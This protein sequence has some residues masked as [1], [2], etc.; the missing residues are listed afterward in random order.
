MTERLHER[1]LTLSDITSEEHKDASYNP[2]ATLGVPENA[3]IADVRVAYISKARLYHPDMI[4]PLSSIEARLAAHEKMVQLN[5]AYEMIHTKYSRKEWNTVAGYSFTTVY[6][7]KE[8]HDNQEIKLEGDAEVIIYPNSW[9]YW[10]PGAYLLYDLGPPDDHPWYP[11]SFR[12]ATVVK[13]LFIY[14]ELQEGK[15]PVNPALLKSF[16]DTF[17]LNNTQRELF[18]KLLAPYES[19]TYIMSALGIQHDKDVPWGEI[20]N[21]WYYSNRFR[22]H[23]NEMLTLETEPDRSY[24]PIRMVTDEN[25]LILEDYTKTILTEPDIMLLSTL[26]YGPLLTRD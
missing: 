24:H 4:D 21:N 8:G 5:F 25:Q 17:T 19:S 18:N 22:R 10:V 20:V 3:T 12:H 7:E 23:T 14:K 9:E 1:P 6:N 13:H 16:F 2:Y 26:A 11:D 15:Q